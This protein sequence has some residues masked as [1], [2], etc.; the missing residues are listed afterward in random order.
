M[1]VFMASLTLF[2]FQTVN[3]AVIDYLFAQRHKKVTDGLQC[4]MQSS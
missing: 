4:W 1:Y 2:G 3:D